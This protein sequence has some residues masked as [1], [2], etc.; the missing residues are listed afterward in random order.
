MLLT[1]KQEEKL[2]K[3]IAS[4]DNKAKKKLFSANLFLVESVAKHYLPNK[5][6]KSIKELMKAGSSGLEKAIDKYNIKSDYKFSTY[7]TWWIRHEI[8][9]LLSIKD[10]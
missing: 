8:H 4:G 5:K 10:I 9:N 6:K 7:S 2:F 1:K 3:R